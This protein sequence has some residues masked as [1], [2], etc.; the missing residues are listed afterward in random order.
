MNILAPIKSAL[1]ATEGWNDKLIILFLFLFV[2]SSTF[3]IAVTQIAY[4]TAL[5]LW[6]FKMINER[7]PL[8]HSTPFDYYFLAFIL[9]EL[10]ATIFSYNP[11]ESLYYFHKRLVIIP[12]IYLLGYWLRSRQNL[13][14][15][16]IIYFLS[17]FIV[18]MYGVF[19]VGLHFKEYLHFERRVNLFQFYMTAGGLMMI[20]AL[21]ILAFISHI[22]IPKRLKWMGIITIVPVL[23]SLLFTFTR[24][25]WLGFIAG[26]ALISYNRSKKIFVGLVI[27]LA[28][29]L[30]I[31]PPEFKDR[32]F[33]IVDPY[34]PTNVE[35]LE[36]W[37]T[38]WKIFLDYPI[39]GIGDVGIETYYQKYGPPGSNPAGHLHNNYINLLVKIGIIGFVIIMTLF[40]KI[41]VIE[42]KTA[43]KYKNDWLINSTALGAAAAFIGFHVN[44]L[45][46]WNFG[47]TEVIMFLWTT[48]GFTIAARSIA[49]S[50][51]NKN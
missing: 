45:F 34:H 44:G 50:E 2:F 3:S 14:A 10:L 30:L 19:D 41:F 4:F 35:R 23:I 43:N 20:S 15:T 24:S 39:L 49:T 9:A 47:D 12:I 21:M 36:M 1:K 17:I 13:E 40:I 16:L 11:S 25:S 29:I 28:I 42:I 31:V 7:K 5:A 18:S 8:V 6:L 51:E 48:V 26:T 22:N 46:E 33:S 27:V 37:Q 32:I 38:G